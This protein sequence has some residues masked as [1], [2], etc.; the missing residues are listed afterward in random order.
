MKDCQ[1]FVDMIKSQFEKYS[2]QIVSGLLAKVNVWIS[3]I[4]SI[5]PQN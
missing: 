4:I 2:V 5:V 3:R 1:K